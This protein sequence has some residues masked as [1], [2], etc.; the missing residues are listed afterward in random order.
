MIS[1]GEPD[2]N[3]KPREGRS[4]KKRPDKS[5]KKRKGRQEVRGQADHVI[6]EL[7]AKVPAVPNLPSPASHRKAADISEEDQRD[8]GMGEFVLEYLERLMVP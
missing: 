2:P 8:D 4:A 7:A 5:G 6:A 1:E 3:V